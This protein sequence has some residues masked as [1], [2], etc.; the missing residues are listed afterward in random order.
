M[1]K[2]ANQANWH[3]ELEVKVEGEV[4]RAPACSMTTIPGA[5]SRLVVDLK[6][7]QARRSRLCWVLNPIH[8]DLKGG[9]LRRF[10]AHACGALSRPMKGG[11]CK[12]CAPARGACK[13]IGHWAAYDLGCGSCGA[14][15][16]LRDVKCGRPR[17]D[18]V[19]G[20][21]R[22]LLISTQ[23]LSVVVHQ[24]RAEGRPPPRKRSR[25]VWP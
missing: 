1:T 25:P 10:P 17:G 18:V 16:E 13:E 20:D 8:V 2:T 4:C 11:A 21:G 6:K 14:G 12:D 22:A 23:R 9:P 5:G 15:R 3:S 7:G 19:G 24:R